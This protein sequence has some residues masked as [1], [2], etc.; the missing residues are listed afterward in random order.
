CPPLE[1]NRRKRDTTQHIWNR[2]AFRSVH[3]YF[4]KYTLQS[5]QRPKSSDRQSMKDS[6]VVEVL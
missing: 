6:K 5:Q 2:A 1:E 4:V 3:G